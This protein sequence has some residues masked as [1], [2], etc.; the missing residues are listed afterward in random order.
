MAISVSFP[1]SW[2]CSTGGPGAHPAGCWLPLPHLVTNGSNLQTNWF[3]VFTE[4][5]NSS[6][7]TQ[8]LEW[9]VWSSSSGNNCHAVH[10]SLSSGA[11]VYDSGILTLSHIVSKARPHQW[12]MHFRRLWNGMFDGAGGQYTTVELWAVIQVLCILRHSVL[13]I[14]VQAVIQQDCYESFNNLW[15]AAISGTF[16]VFFFSFCWAK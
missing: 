5:Y 1:F 13:Y 4:L 10:R 15:L 9:R 3:P 2:C 16:Y 12:N 14:H 6:T 7:S 8:S 11:S